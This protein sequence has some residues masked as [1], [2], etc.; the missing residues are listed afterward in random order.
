MKRF[1][2][3]AALLLVF[4]SRAAAAISL[5][6]IGSGANSSFTTPGSLTC[7]ATGLL[8]VLRN[9][10]VIADIEAGDGSGSAAIVVT[11]PTGWTVWP[12]MPNTNQKVATRTEYQTLFYYYGPP[13]S[14]T[15]SVAD[16]GTNTFSW[17]C[18]MW[19]F[20]GT[21]RDTPNDGNA[22][23]GIC[24]TGACTTV[25]APSVTASTGDALVM[26][27]GDGDH[28]VSSITGSPAPTLG[29]NDNAG[30][31]VRAAYILGVS[32]GATTAY[33]FNATSSVMMEGAQVLIA[34]PAALSATVLF[35]SCASTGCSGTP[36][37]KTWAYDPFAQTLKLDS[38]GAWAT[39]P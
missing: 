24:Q 6:A 14:V 36:L 4:A 30:F 20:R 7:S 33:A 23:G 21:K 9:D 2:L 5:V 15:F 1:A 25:T 27:G 29:Y 28:T 19:Q 26:F 3:I 13:R 22:N 32:A 8:P 18:N 39:M 16:G 31:A 17:N 37:A 38:G 35:N 10:L 11:P 34:A 12:G